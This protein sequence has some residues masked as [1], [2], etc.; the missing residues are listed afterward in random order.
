[1]A[2]TILQ[3]VV[4][5]K[6]F[7]R[8][9]YNFSIP[10]SAEDNMRLLYGENGSGKTTVLRMIYACLSRNTDE[11]LRTFLGATFFKSIEIRTSSGYVISAKRERAD[12]GP[13]TFSIESSATNLSS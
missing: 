2:D 13:Y 8:F 11:G 5:E 3:S 9:D 6:L 1:M 4:I 7:G 10:D 12:R